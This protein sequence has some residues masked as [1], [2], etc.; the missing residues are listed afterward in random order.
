MKQYNGFKST[1]V[2]HNKIEKAQKY[3]N[4]S[5]QQQNSS[6]ILKKKHYNITKFQQDDTEQ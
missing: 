2:K 5:L 4:M 6:G 3:Y 1:I